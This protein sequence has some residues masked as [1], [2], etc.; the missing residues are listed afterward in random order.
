MLNLIKALTIFEAYNPNA[1]THCE[2]DIMAICGVEV[3]DVSEAHKNELLELGFHVGDSC[4]E[5]GFE[6][7]EWGSC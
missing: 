5:E 7:Y 4:G 6:S 2:H 3:S 1:S